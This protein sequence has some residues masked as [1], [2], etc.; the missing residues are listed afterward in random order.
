MEF[1]LKFVDDII[2]LEGKMRRKPG[3]LDLEHQT[4][5]GGALIWLGPR[6][7][8]S[9]EVTASGMQSWRLSGRRTG[10]PYLVQVLRLHFLHLNHD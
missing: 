1:T 10:G 7:I 4:L 8:L 9:S 5:E 2:G 3:E 6:C